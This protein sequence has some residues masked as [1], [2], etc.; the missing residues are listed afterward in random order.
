MNLRKTDG[1]PEVIAVITLYW[2][3]RKPMPLIWE[4]NL[5]SCIFVTLIWERSKG[6]VSL[7]I[8]VDGMGLTMHHSCCAGSSFNPS[9]PLV[10]NISSFWRERMPFSFTEKIPESSQEGFY[11]SYG[12]TDSCLHKTR[13]GHSFVKALEHA[14]SSGS[15]SWRKNS[16]RFFQ[17]GTHVP[18]WG[19]QKSFWRPFQVLIAL[20]LSIKFPPS[21]ERAFSSN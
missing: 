8:T 15:W 20:Q 18:T 1:C 2:I 7:T 21:R 10:S 13:H 5:K 14:L 12:W 6:V 9:V 17:Q 19:S 3:L 16:I 4:L 11:L